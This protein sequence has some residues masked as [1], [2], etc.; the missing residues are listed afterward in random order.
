MMAPTQ[1]EDRVNYGAKKFSMW[2]FIFTSFMLFAALTSAF[3]VY[4][5]GKGHGLN[6]MMPRAFMYSTMVIIISS[7]TLFLASR[8]AKQSQPEKQRLFLWLTFFLGIAFFV[9]QIYAWY[10][11]TYKMGIYFSFNPNASQ[12]FIY[13][14]SGMHL[15]HIIAALLVLLR[16]IISTYRN[17]TQAKNL[18]KM[19][20]TSIFW[21]FLD[22]IWIY[23]YVFL[24]L[25]QY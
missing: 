23:L 25:N 9:I 11:L 10:V 14:F 19:E 5:G 2:I 20:M 3:I 7:M 24:L 22:I 4:S 6:V 13:V 16:T 1:Q 18:F 12:S 17:T 21:H 8:A 15:L